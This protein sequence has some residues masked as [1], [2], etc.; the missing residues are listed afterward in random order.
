MTDQAKKDLAQSYHLMMDLAAWKHFQVNIL[1]RIEE[2]ATKDEDAI[3][4]ETLDSSIGKLGE[5]RGKR[6]A[7]DKIKNDLEYILEGLK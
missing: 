1:N 7:I 4:I 2:Q 6:A 5:C 3:P